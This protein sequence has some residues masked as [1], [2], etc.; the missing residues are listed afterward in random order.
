MLIDIATIE[1][2]ERQRTIV[3]ETINQLED[4]I[5]SKGLFH[6]P[7]IAVDEQGTFL[8]A[9]E[10]RLR[11]ILALHEK[12]R[13]FSYNGTV[14]TP[15]LCPVTNLADLSPAD[16]L[17]AELE[18]NIIR[19]EIPWQDKARA[20]AAIHAMR[21][22]SNPKQ[23][24]SATADELAAKAGKES[25]SGRAKVAIRNATILAQNLH[26]PSVSKARNATEALGILIKEEN[27]KVEAELIARKHKK[28]EEEGKALPTIRVIHGSLVDEMPL[29]PDGEIDLVCG[30]LPYGIDAD[31]GGFR[32]RT[33]EHHNYDDSAG[34]AR[35]LMQTVIVES[36][37]ITKPRANL[38]LF[39]DIDLFPFF[40]EMCGR[41][42]WKPFRTPIIWQ[43][44]ESEGLAPWGKEG[45]RRTYEMIFFA[46]KG[47]RGLLM[48]PTDIL[49]ENRVSRAARRYGPEKPVGL[50][51]QLIECSTMPGDL[52]L[53]PCCGSGSCLA[54]ARQLNRKAI[55]I[56]LDEAAYNLSVVAASRDEAE[57]DK[58]EEL[59]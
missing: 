34:N 8:V 46:T 40:K 37:R 2:R 47:E 10:H 31:K 44:S 18:E 13:P 57:D 12:Q 26:R 54:A 1:I 23:T 32:S 36:F 19:T 4:S 9:G 15:G 41:M 59:A 49:R 29:L 38:F 22:A 42:G 27:A 35:S 53:D 3:Q 33:V 48:S 52:V 21:V 28:M 55:G 51:K 11:A 43:K 39:G 24:M 6:A 30:D 5:A 25:A 20:L 50:L 14:V 17:E 16:L 45:F 56:E 58:T 7:V